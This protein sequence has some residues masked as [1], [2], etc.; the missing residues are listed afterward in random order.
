MRGWSDGEVKVGEPVFGR[1]TLARR[2]DGFG[3]RGGSRLAMGVAAKVPLAKQVECCGG[4]DR[5]DRGQDWV[6][7]GDVACLGAAG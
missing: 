7:G 1:G 2:P 5:L 3:A 6:R 4:G